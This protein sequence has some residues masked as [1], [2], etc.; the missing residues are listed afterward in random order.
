MV[1]NSGYFAQF[2]ERM[3][4]GMLKTLL[5]VGTLGMSNEN[6]TKDL[7][8]NKGLQFTSGFSFADNISELGTSVAINRPVCIYFVDGND[9]LVSPSAALEAEVPV[10]IRLGAQ[11]FKAVIP[12]VNDA[13]RVRGDY[14]GVLMN[15]AT[16]QPLYPVND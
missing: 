11:H 2:A 14:R 10:C 13:H 5:C 6:F 1:R 3:G 9:V 15:L 12:I 4:D 8:Q 16:L 7:Y